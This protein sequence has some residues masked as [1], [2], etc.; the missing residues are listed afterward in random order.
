MNS[1]DHSIFSKKNDNGDKEDNENDDESSISDLE[2][3]VVED[4]EED[5]SA[6]PEEFFPLALQ[7][8]PLFAIASRPS[9]QYKEEDPLHSHWRTFFR[10]AASTLEHEVRASKPSSL[11]R[12]N[13]IDPNLISKSTAK[14]HL[15]SST[16][17]T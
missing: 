4:F 9:V 10:G 6:S 13:E 14:F 12:S 5:E 7:Y 3:S 16:R 2:K 15:T 11:I 1:I 17:I 8:S